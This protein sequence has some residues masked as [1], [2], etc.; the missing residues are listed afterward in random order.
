VPTSGEEADGVVLVAATRRRTGSATLAGRLATLGVRDAVA[1][2]TSGCA[3]L[4]IRRRF[5]VGPPLPHRQS[6]QRYGLCC[7]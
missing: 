4:G 2:D 6:I 3:M 5:L 7:R 1:T